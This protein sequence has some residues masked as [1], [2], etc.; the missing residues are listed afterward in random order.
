MR[1]VDGVILRT[2]GG[3]KAR[4]IKTHPSFALTRCYNTEFGGASQAASRLKNACSQLTHLADYNISP[5]LLSVAKKIQQMDTTGELGKRT[6]AISQYKE[7]PEGFGFNRR[8]ALDAVIRHQLDCTIQRELLT[9]TVQLPAL[10]PGTNFYIPGR[11]PLFRLITVLSNVPDMVYTPAGYQPA[12]TQRFQQDAAT[13]YTD[14]YSTAAN[15]AG[16]II[17]LQLQHTLVLED[18]IS[19][20]VSVG[21]EFGMPAA[22]NEIKPIQYAGCAKIL[23]LG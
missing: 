3:A 4:K 12:T 6:V 15:C 23:A 1:G 19:L 9:A 18:T 8:T 22:G 21:I 10:Y 17:R 2:K 13:V 5:A 7:M 14:W 20:V 16:Q 11:Y